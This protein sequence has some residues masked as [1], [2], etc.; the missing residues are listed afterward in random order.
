MYAN[1][2]NAST[3]CGVETRRAISG[4]SSWIWPTMLPIG[5]STSGIQIS[6]GSATALRIGRGA[7]GAPGDLERDRDHQR[8]EQPPQEVGRERL[9]DEHAA[10]DARDRRD[11]DDR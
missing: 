10:L 2:L 11:A 6:S 4:C 7:R 5:S 8:P 3:R 1:V 9:R